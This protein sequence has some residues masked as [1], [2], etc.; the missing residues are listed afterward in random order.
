MLEE[1]QAEWNVIKW[2]N[3]KAFFNWRRMRECWSNT[4]TNEQNGACNLST[5]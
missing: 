5:L 3:V 1:A 2:M 4:Q